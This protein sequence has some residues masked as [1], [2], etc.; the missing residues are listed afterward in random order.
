MDFEAD[1]SRVARAMASVDGFVHAGDQE[2]CGLS[3]LEAMACGT[4]VAARN[5]AGLAEAVAD[6]CGIAVPSGRTDDWAA[7]IEA[8]CSPDARQVNSALQKARRHDWVRVLAK[9]QRRY[10]LS[11][12]RQRTAAAPSLDA[13]AA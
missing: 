8:L 10:A 3:V 11:V 12:S 2:T 7:A 9:L 13:A 4:P 5:A 6:D 1:P